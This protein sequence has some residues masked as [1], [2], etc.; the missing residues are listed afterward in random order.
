MVTVNYHDI[1]WGF[2]SHG[3]EIDPVLYEGLR[4]MG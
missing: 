4:T 2:Y 3:W 1:T